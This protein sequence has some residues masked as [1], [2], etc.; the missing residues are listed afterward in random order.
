MPESRLPRLWRFIEFIET[1][2]LVGGY[3]LLP[4]NIHV[5]R[6]SCPSRRI[7]ADRNISGTVVSIA[8]CPDSSNFLEESKILMVA[9]DWEIARW[10]FPRT[11]RG[12]GLNSPACHPNQFLVFDQHLPQSLEGRP[13]CVEIFDDLLFLW[14]LRARKDKRE[15]TP[16][17]NDREHSANQNTKSK[18]F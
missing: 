14:G 10:M 18:Q 1:R 4:A 2:D 11:H 5:P 13:M 16:C 17:Q 7:H 8:M 9:I 6:I 3:L 15:E 12:A